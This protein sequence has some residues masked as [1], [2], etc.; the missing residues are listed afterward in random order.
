MKITLIKQ[1]TNGDTKKRRQLYENTET[2]NEAKL[3]LSEY[4][5]NKYVGEIGLG[6]PPQTLKVIFDTGS[7]DLWIPGPKCAKCSEDP[8]FNKSRSET[9]KQL[10]DVF[11]VDYG[12]GK[13]T[14]V[15]GVDNVLIGNLV[16]EG[17]HFGEVSS[18]HSFLA[19]LELDGLAGIAFRGLATI[20]KPSLLETFYQ[21]NPS[22]QKWFSIYYSSKELLS[23]IWFGGYDLTIIGNNA[24]WNYSPVMR[25][26]FGDFKHWAVKMHG[27]EVRDRL[28][29]DVLLYACSSG[30]FSVIDTG[31]PGIG[32][33]EP[34]YSHVVGIING[35]L[36]C[37][38][39]TC[40]NAAVED[41][42]DFVFQLSPDLLLPL[43]AENY[44]TCSR[45]GECVYKIQPV[46]G[47]TYWVLGG[48]FLEAYYTLFDFGNQR[49]GF[50]CNNGTCTNGEW[51]SPKSFLDLEQFRQW[52]NA[53]FVAFFA[54]AV[55]STV[56]L[57]LG[58]A[59]NRLCLK[60]STHLKVEESYL[61]GEDTARGHNHYPDRMV[62]DTWCEDV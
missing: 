4:L 33:P 50:A 61:L 30:C 23:H 14:G 51:D 13:V 47:E 9:Y 39:I 22:V 52:Q 36:D 42:P 11:E 34:F 3:I 37:K 32:I 20:T 49:I 16:S 27:F 29:N 8:S 56:Y 15:E 28:S 6:S 31:T 18:D 54:L 2:S 43:R 41:F 45:W 5:D 53:T 38:G 57:I 40:L 10:G 17:V 60:S 25:R 44:V 21:Q 59:S 55:S 19:D 58:L 62:K 12:S 48:V 1:S 46:R 24:T 26:S 7:S 35:N